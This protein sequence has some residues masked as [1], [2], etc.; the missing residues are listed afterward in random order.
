MLEELWLSPPLSF[1]APLEPAAAGTGKTTP[2]SQLE[3]MM[4]QR[5]PLSNLK[6]VDLLATIKLWFFGGLVLDQTSP[7]SY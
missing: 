7:L 5:I 6:T 2:H 1:N 3:W 4:N